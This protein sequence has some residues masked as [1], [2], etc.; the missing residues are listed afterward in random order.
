MRILNLVGGLVFLPVAIA[1]LL[2]WPIV[3]GTAVVAI[4]HFVIKCW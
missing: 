1:R 2:F 3:V 4:V